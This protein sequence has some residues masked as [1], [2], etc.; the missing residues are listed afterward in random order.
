[1][2]TVIPAEAVEA[3]LLAFYSAEDA[4]QAMHAAL[5]AAA[6]HMSA[7]IEW[8]VRWDSKSTG[9]AGERPWHPVEW[10]EDQETARAVAATAQRPWANPRVVKRTAPGEWQAVG[11]GAK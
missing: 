11:V 5:E 6:P 1:M 4:E 8:G 9:P 3:A 7:H 10:C 2:W